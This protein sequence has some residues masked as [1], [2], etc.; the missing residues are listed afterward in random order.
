M[1]GSVKALTAEV[2]AMAISGETGDPGGHVTAL[3]SLLARA[4]V[5]F[6]TSEPESAGFVRSKRQLATAFVGALERLCITGAPAD[7]ERWSRALR[8]QLLQGSDLEVLDVD[9]LNHLAIM[10]FSRSQYKRAGKAIKAAIKLCTKLEGSG[11]MTNQS[12][13][14]RRAA[15]YLN[16]CDTFSRLRRHD[17]ALHSANSA[18]SL[19]EFTHPDAEDLAGTELRVSAMH[20][21]GLQRQQTG[22]SYGSVE[23]I[24]AASELAADKLPAD[25]ALRRH[26]ARHASR[27]ARPEWDDSATGAPS[28]RRRKVALPALS[29]TP[30]LPPPTAMTPT[31][32]VTTLP[33][34]D[35]ESAQKAKLDAETA[36]KKKQQAAETERI[37]AAEKVEAVRAAAERAETT[38]A[39][40]K[41][42][43]D[44]AQKERDA[45]ALVAAKE[46]EDAETAQRKQEQAEAE[47][48]AERA[49]AEE[50]ETERVAEV[51]LAAA[52]EAGA[53]KAAADAAAQ[54]ARE[55]AK[56]KAVAEAVAQVGEIAVNCL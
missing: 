33:P 7:A 50:A 21:V 45:A 3:E 31:P 15:L 1:A 51:K 48:E 38:Q 9:C 26:I 28:R 23:I 18:L 46:K 56:A 24:N 37:A 42:A 36:Q 29:S 55:E 44:A 22:D 30:P 49:A 27:I 2:L 20:S 43:A 35:A 4:L 54:I 16:S 47:R 11:I 19:L 39:E 6:R 10:H 12:A 52:K 40:A 14:T 8:T 25:S 32:M 17:E 5:A 34:V 41:A 53:A 13:T